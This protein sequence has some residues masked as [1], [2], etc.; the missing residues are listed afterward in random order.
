MKPFDTLDHSERI[1]PIGSPSAWMDGLVE[2]MRGR[3]QEW[4]NLVQRIMRDGV[5]YPGGLVV[6]DIT[7]DEEYP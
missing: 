7:E 5:H 6:L 4:P 1:G 2:A 3:H